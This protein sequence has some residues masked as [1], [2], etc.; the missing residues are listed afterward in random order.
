MKQAR[1]WKGIKGSGLSTV[2]KSRFCLNPMSIPMSIVCLFPSS[3]P[4][5]GPSH[6]QFY[7]TPRPIS[8]PHLPHTKANLIPMS[9]SF[10]FYPT[11]RP[12]S[13]PVLSHTQTHLIPSSTPLQ[14][15]SHSQFYPTPRPTSFPCL[16][17]S[18]VYG[19]GLLAC[20]LQNRAFIANKLQIMLSFHMMSITYCDGNLRV[21]H[22]RGGLGQLLAVPE[23]KSEKLISPAGSYTS[24]W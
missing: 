22:T 8:F 9:T 11:S 19:R 23:G 2:S 12:I 13:F 17:H 6:S 20:H 21:K 24:P 14:G 10:P 3:T 5:P 1:N 4:H 7:P 18:Q 16:L 15:Q